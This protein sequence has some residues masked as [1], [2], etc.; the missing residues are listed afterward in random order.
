MDNLD[1]R[2]DDLTGRVL[3]LGAVLGLSIALIGLVMLM[4]GVPTF[5][6]PFGNPASLIIESQGADPLDLMELGLLIL[7]ASPMVGIMTLTIGFIWLKRLRFVMVSALLLMLL[8][9]SLILPVG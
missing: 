3:L 5:R 7:M 9:A 2:L 6:D 8:I 1:A 4:L